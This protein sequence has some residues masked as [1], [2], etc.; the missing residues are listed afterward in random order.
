MICPVPFCNAEGNIL[1]CMYYFDS[2]Y[3]KKPLY[4]IFIRLCE[5]HARQISDDETVVKIQILN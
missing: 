2:K 5:K 1:I 4:R 3:S